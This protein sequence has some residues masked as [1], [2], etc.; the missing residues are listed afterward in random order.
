M[1]SWHLWCLCPFISLLKWGKLP[2]QVINISQ[3]Q[4]D[5]DGLY[6]TSIEVKDSVFFGFILQAMIL[7][8][9]DQP[10]WSQHRFREKP[11]FLSSKTPLK[12]IESSIC[13][14]LWCFS[15]TVDGHKFCTTWDHQ[16]LYI[17]KSMQNQLVLGI[18]WSLI[19]TFSINSIFEQLL[20]LI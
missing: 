1:V 12:Q 18:W 8:L 3:M 5:V 13:E 20:L 15:E 19:K 7:A 4:F 11:R 10:Q 16:K 14:N 6:S 17:I 2:P 9:W